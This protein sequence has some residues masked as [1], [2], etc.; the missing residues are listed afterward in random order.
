MGCATYWKDD[1]C[2]ISGWD[3][4]TGKQ[5]WKFHTIARTGEPGGDTWGKLPDMMRA[6]GETWIVGSYDPELDLTYWG[7]AQTKPF[8]PASRGLG[9]TVFDKSLYTNATVALKPTTGEL[10]WFHQ[11]ITGESLDQDEVYERVLVNIGPQKVYFT[12]GKAGILWKGDRTTGKFLGFKAATFQNVFERIDPATG[13]V[14]YRPDIIEQQVGQLVQVCPSHGKDW[15]TMSYSPPTNSLIVPINQVCTEQRGHA[16]E[17]KEGAGGPGTNRNYFEMPGTDGKLGKLAAYDVSTM[18]ELWSVKQR[19][20]FTTGVLTT[21]SGIGFVG[22]VDRSFQ[23]FDSK[24][25]EI[26]WRT[27]L[28]T[29]VQGYPITFAINGSRRGGDDRQRRGQSTACPPRAGPGDSSSAKWRS[30]VCIRAG[31]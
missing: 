9:A 19:A 22:D 2:F 11:H 26:L 25:G 16:I 27:R 10:A 17:A 3:A 1:R 23:A 30:V 21:A 5:L 29:A 28:G 31:G 8:M 6:G 14:T 7:I 20:P 4:K 12:M 18:K 15:A 13:V 24:T